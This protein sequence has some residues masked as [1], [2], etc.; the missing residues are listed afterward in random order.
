MDL[1]TWQSAHCPRSSFLA[2]SY[3]RRPI[4]NLPFLLKVDVLKLI[5]DEFG[6]S[7]HLKFKVIRCFSKI[8]NQRINV[9]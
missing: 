9:V 4:Y 6:K 5:D 7:L 3:I 8:E 1:S 2:H